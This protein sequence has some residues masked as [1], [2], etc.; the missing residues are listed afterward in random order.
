MQQ[1]SPDI[2]LMERI[3]GGD[4]RA[5]SALVERYL[6]KAYTVA[7]RM[8]YSP[9]DAEEAVQDAFTK[10]W[11]NALQFDARK[12]AFGT[13][14][15]RILA[16]T[17]MDAARR[18]PTNTAIKDVKDTLD[19][20]LLPD[21]AAS[22]RQEAQRIRHAVQKLPENQRMA[23]VLCYF[24]EMT[25]AEAAEV[26]GLHIKALEGLLVRARKQLHERLSD[27]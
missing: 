16:N 2:R 18:R 23:L 19:T 24:E 21:E 12:A 13:W 11:V 22:L 17:C 10:V 5:F 20:A 8:L 14:F 15:Y 27:G 6:P 25:N 1:E 26:M 4:Q 7:A 9:Q 3:A